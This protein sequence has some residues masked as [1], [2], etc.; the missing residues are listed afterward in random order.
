M[1]FQVGV[2]LSCNESGGLGEDAE[3]VVIESRNRLLH[4]V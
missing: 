4:I 1:Q 2:F 3:A